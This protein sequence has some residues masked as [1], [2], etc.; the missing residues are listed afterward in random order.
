MCSQDKNER[1][2][3]T[4]I[5]RKKRFEQ[6][7]GTNVWEKLFEIVLLNIKQALLLRA[8]GRKGDPNAGISDGNTQ[9][10]MKFSWEKVGITGDSYRRHPLVS[11]NA[12]T[13]AT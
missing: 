4:V 2:K 5:K 12:V 3:Y 1:D 10:G 13:R 7:F 11:D 9:E 6:I 8:G